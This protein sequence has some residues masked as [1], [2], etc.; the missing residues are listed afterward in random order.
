[1]MQKIM[2]CF[3][4]HSNKT[5]RF[6]STH[7][8]GLKLIYYQC[9]TCGFIFQSPKNS[10]TLDPDF[11]SETYRKI[12]QDSAEPTPK[13]LWVQQKRAEVLLSTVKTLIFGEPDRHLD[14]GASSGLLLETFK[15][16]YGCESVGIEPGIAYREFAERQGLEMYPSIDSL[17]K[18]ESQRFDFISI[19]HVLEHLENPLETLQTIRT[20][21]L[22]ENGYLLIEV[23]NFYFHDSYELAHLTCFTPHTLKEIVK[24]AGY[25]ILFTNTHGLPRSSLLNLYITL[26]ARPE[27]ETKDKPKIIPERFVREK[28]RLG[29]L[30]RKIIQKIAPEKAWIP[31]PDE[32][33][34]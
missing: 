13:D 10:N 27:P 3:L 9:E 32:I 2:D 31:I 29:F 14:I 18:P 11:Y 7:S 12:Y 28:R 6:E 19:I 15:Q 33:F 30:Y 5:T 21:L 20:A 22:K 17:L 8:F 16:A 26:L 1:M 34:S 24:Q 23:P 25:Q 4:C